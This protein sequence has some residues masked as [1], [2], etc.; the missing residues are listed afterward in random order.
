MVESAFGGIC[1]PPPDAR[2]VEDEEPVSTDLNDDTEDVE[3]DDAGADGEGRRGVS[4]DWPFCPIR[5]AERNSIIF[6]VL[7]LTFC[8]AL[9]S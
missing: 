1:D 4:H 9:S 2:I 3:V 7:R 8:Q 6:F 5:W